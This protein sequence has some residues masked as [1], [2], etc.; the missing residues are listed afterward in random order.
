[1]HLQIDWVSEWQNEPSYAP[2]EEKEEKKVS[3][4]ELD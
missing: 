4:A 1:M 3:A 2:T